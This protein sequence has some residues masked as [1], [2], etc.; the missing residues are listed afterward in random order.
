MTTRDQAEA[1]ATERLQIIAPLVDEATDAAQRRQVTTQVVDQ[2]GLSARTLRRWVAAVPGGGL[3]RPAPARAADPRPRRYSG[4]GAGRR[5]SVAPG[6]AAPE[7]AANHSNARVGRPGGPRHAQTQPP[8][9]TADRPGVQCPP[10]RMGQAPHARKGGGARFRAGP[11][12]PRA[13]R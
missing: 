2:T 7:C 13:S 5:H 4:G 6:S 10:R 1:I 11:T 9:G 8:A 3:S 12:D